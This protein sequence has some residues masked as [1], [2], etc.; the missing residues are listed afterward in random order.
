MGEFG[1]GDDE[2]GDTGDRNTAGGGADY[3]SPGAGIW[4]RD[5]FFVASHRDDGIVARWINT[6]M[7]PGGEELGATEFAGRPVVI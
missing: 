5:V 4:D 1:A 2:D 6:I 7:E 3:G